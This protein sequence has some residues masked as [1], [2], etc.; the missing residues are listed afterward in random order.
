MRMIGKVSSLETQPERA[1]VQF[2]DDTHTDT[3]AMG[4]GCYIEHY[5][6]RCFIFKPFLDFYE[7]QKVPI[8]NAL[9]C[10]DDKYG[11]C[12]IICVNQAL[13]FKDEEV[14]LM[15]NF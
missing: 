9:Y 11:E 10:Y 14:A 7:G 13:Y 2:E 5:L 4:K 1:D 8:L 3:C 6:D 15:S 12:Y